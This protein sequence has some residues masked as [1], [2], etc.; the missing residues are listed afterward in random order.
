[1]LVFGMLTGLRPQE[2]RTLKKVEVLQDGQGRSYVLI[3]VHKTSRTARDHQSRTVPLTKEVA[4]IVRRQSARF[5]KAEFVFMTDVGTP[6]ATDVFR[7]KLE[8][9]CSRAKIEP[10]PPYALRHTFASMNADGDTNVV[11]LGQLMGHS[12]TRTTARYIRASCEHHVKAVERGAEHIW[13][14][15]TKPAEADGVGVLRPDDAVVAGGEVGPRG[16]A[17]KDHSV[18]EGVGLQGAPRV[19]AQVSACFDHDRS[20]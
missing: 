20:A 16:V 13:S 8:R 4:E 9:W 18:V 3:E 11:A 6:Y 19:T 7:R 2:L 17:E 1:M 10:K 15:L 5:P 12:S 14:L